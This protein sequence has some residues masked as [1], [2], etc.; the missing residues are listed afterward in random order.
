MGNKAWK[1]WVG[2]PTIVGGCLVAGGAF[3]Q[4]ASTLQARI[5][6]ARDRVVSALVNVQPITDVYSSGERRSSTG[7][8]SGF[9]LDDRGHVITNY[10]VAGKAKRLIIT[11]SDKRRVSGVLVG[12]D[13][14]TDIA[15]LRIE[16]MVNDLPGSVVLGNSADLEVGEYV[17]ALGSPLAL[18][19]SLSFGVVS[20]KNRYLPD[21]FKL[22]TGEKTGSF[23][24][25]IQTDAAINPGNS[26]GPLVN[27]SGQVVGVNA[28]GA[29]GA[30]SIGFA[31]PINIVKEVVEELID[32][33]RVKRSWLGLEFQPREELSQYYAAG[34]RP[35]V[36]ISSVAPDS[37]ASRAGLRAGDVLVSLDGTPIS[38]EFTE[39]LPVIYKQVADT[40]IGKDVELV[41]YRG[42][43]QLRLVASTE[44]RSR[45]SSDEMECASWGFTARGITQEVVREFNLPDGDGV[46]VAGVRPNDVA[47]RAQLFPGDRIVQIEG[48]RLRD[49]AHLEEVY[50]RLDDDKS[51]PVV[52][53]VMRRHSRRLILIEAGYEESP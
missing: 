13:P 49:L 48:E 46:F 6:E 14:L 16:P 50:R 21:S 12:E 11:L 30:S 3:A 20:S 18:E 10:H 24:T 19:R 51:T 15:V 32:H 47:N 4:P 31:I 7:V 27:L 36:V 25:W 40:P 45:S 29:F 37:P 26:G 5:F 53:T 34:E 9:V 43:D 38:A 17:M 35:G 2:V 44:E 42:E 23:N 41:A 52:L 22:P 28:R 39:Q 1:T 8:G 33:G